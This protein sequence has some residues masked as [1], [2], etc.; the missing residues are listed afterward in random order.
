LSRQT[1][2]VDTARITELL[3]AL[4]SDKNQER[5]QAEKLFQQ[6]KASEP[7]AIALGM[8]A[9]VGTQSADV[10]VRQHGAVLLRQ[11]VGS[12][13]ISGEDYVLT[14][15]AHQHRQELAAGLLQL[16]EA[17]NEPRMQR[18]IGDVVAKLADSA[19][20]PSSQRGWLSPQVGGWP[21]LLPL[22]FRMSDT[23][24]N[25]N[26][27]SCE[28]SLRLLKELVSTLKKEVVG[29]QQQLGQVIQ[30]A[31]AGEDLKVRV[32]AFLLICEIVGEVEKKEWAPL[33]ATCGV[34][35]Q[36]LEQLAQTSSD[37]L[38]ECLQALTMVA[39]VEP[40]FFKQSL[41]SALQPAKFMSTIV[42]QRDS[43]DNSVRGLCME[44]LVTYCEK[45]PKWLKKSLPAFAPIAIE[46][47]MDLL[48]EVDDSEEDLR[49]WV[50][51]MDDEEGEEDADENFHTG[52]DA[53][54]RIVK[55]VG[56]DSASS[57]L[58][59][60]IGRFSQQD[61]WQA[62][63]AAL[64]AIRQTVEY[65]E[66]TDHVSEMAKLL[67][68][69]V[70]HQHPRV[71]YTALHAVGQ[72]ANDQ[73]PHFQETWHQTVMPLL[74]KKMDDQVDRVAAM[75]M[76]AFVSFGEELDN[77]LMATYAN[78]FMQKL[79]AR[80]QTT[81]HRMV[82]EESITSIAVIA[83]VIEKDFSQYYDGIMPMLKQLILNA[84]GEK[85]N[86]L[87]GKA[88]E[89]MS[90]LGLAVGK[91][92][93]LPDADQAITEMMR[94]PL[95]ADDMQR[96][97]IKEA[98]ERVCKCLKGDFKKFLPHMLPGIFNSFKIETEAANDDDD[99]DDEYV[100]MTV[101]EGKLV[102][103]KSTKLEEMT[104]SVQL[105][106]TFIT[107]MEGAYREWVQPTA[108]ALLP[109]LQSSESGSMYEEVRGEAFQVWAQLI[110][111]VKA[112]DTV[113][114]A[115]QS[116]VAAELLRT[117]LQR[118]I[119]S[120]QE[121]DDA[122]TLREAI[123]GVGE[124]VK[125]CGP[126]VLN[127]QEI[128]QLVQTCFKFIDDSFKR[129]SASA[130]EKKDGAAGAPPELQQDEDD[131]DAM[132]DE[133]DNLRQT[134]VESLGCIMQVAPVEFLQCL[135][136]CQQR[137]SLWLQAKQNRVLAL[138]LGCELI[139]HLKEQSEPAW[140]IFMPAVFQS[141]CDQD[142]EE[143]I[144]AAY[145]VNLAAPLASFSQA[146]PEAFRR[147]AQVVN[148]PAPR[149][150]QERAKVALDNATSA[151]LALA[152]AKGELCP[153]E[154]QPWQFIVRRLPLKD[155]EEEARKVHEQ[156][157]NL[158]MEEHAGILENGGAHLG[159]ILSA[160]A[161]VYKQEDLCTKEADQKILQV[162]QRLPR[163]SLVKLA[164]NFSEKQQKKIER[165]LTTEAVLHHGG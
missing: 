37:D 3:K 148:G 10:A 108:E 103:V 134:I 94:S 118:A 144:P 1:M 54:D 26:R 142:P 50:S 40:D 48:Y 143:R 157:V 159:K 125:N 140:P 24:A 138:F 87:R 59:S 127:G 78:E 136:E 121:D 75:A 30:N 99:D 91:E 70:D 71:R 17:E 97:Y 9:V 106:R 116:G 96:E 77:T 29:A 164:G 85:E 43:V 152:T 141:L 133:E 25:P 98:A 154:V 76:S 4:N 36:M 107:E 124:C 61:A 146:A 42:K 52:E 5:Q 27:G 111:C 149:K 84:K 19:C 35:N 20:H 110:K 46:C 119:A 156:L 100:T 101:G 56:M 23:S 113:A 58:F 13:A 104:H 132:E 139:R 57:A 137:I 53:I 72:L 33:I 80:L 44:W 163:E 126:G 120:M 11:L 122:E 102:K 128:L 109:L 28:S 34:L 32:A 47:S 130:S 105:L 64:A 7:D 2:A 93:F 82:Q 115:T 145:A 18:K 15:M 66:E 39:E 81:G 62:K 16:F 68:A 31:L 51:R 55:A 158:V 147:L 6:A 63:H 83:G 90:L 49:A 162:F 123:D 67:L 74:L 14:R 153:P 150:S 151:L 135:P 95:E 92:K 65:V 117:F 114:G 12:T 131:E 160:L 165:M 161:E 60:L 69:H 41:T 129:S 73:A 8:L 22:V 112:A 79:V 38:E 45:K 89:C 21:Q 88:F 155:D 86:R